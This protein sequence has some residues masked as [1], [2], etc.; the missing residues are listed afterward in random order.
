M[1]NLKS[2]YPFSLIKNG[3]LYDYPKLDTDLDIEVLILG[4]GISGALTAYHLINAGVSCTVVDARSIGLGS[5]CA[6]TSLLQY[7]IDVSLT[8]LSKK[9]GADNAVRAYQLGTESIRKLKDISDNIGFDEFS[10]RK[11]LYYAD[12]KSDVQM[13]KEEFQLRHDNGLDVYFMEQ[14]EIK[15]RFGIDSKAAIFSTPAAVTNAYTF[16]HALH[17]YNL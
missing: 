9:V 1:L 2:G 3:L 8:E 14:E 15:N 6:S 7:E 4:G 10:S 11:S 12:R 13:I 17:Q 16:T 5:T